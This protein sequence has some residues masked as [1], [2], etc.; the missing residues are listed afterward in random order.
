M[1]LQIGFSLDE[2]SGIVPAPASS[3]STSQI[4][5]HV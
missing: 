2:A 4:G 3:C 1:G 5:K